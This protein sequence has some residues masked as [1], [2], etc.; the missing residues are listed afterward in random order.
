MK[1]TAIDVPC[2]T[3][4]PL[5]GDVIVTHAARTCV[6]KD[7]PMMTRAIIRENG[8]YNASD[9]L[10]IAPEDTLDRSSLIRIVPLL[11][12]FS[13]EPFIHAS[14]FRTTKAGDS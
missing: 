1:L 9:R 13:R 2:R 6:A 7:M 3:L 8:R 14:E 10:K 11:Y 4:A 5:D 12:K